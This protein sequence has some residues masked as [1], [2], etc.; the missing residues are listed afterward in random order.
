MTSEHHSPR[1]PLWLRKL[2]IPALIGGIAGFAASY[3]ML[4][5]ID[6]DMVGGLGTSESIAALVG[7]LYCVIAVGLLIGTANP[8]LGA[9]FLNVEDA[10]ELREQHRMLVYS[11]LAMVLWGVAL[12]A[13]ALAA[14]G[15]PVSQ[16]A[17]LAVGA[18]GLVIGTLL[19]VQSYRMS[20]ELMLAMNLEAAALTYSLAVLV[21]GT[22]AVIAHLGYTAGPQPLDLLTT[23]YVLVLVATFIVIGRRGMLTIK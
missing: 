20:D 4:H 8:R 21:L 19:A 5:F 7:V 1:Y 14:P 6:S 12:L 22:W 17:A 23:F 10:E 18:S 16:N 11:G 15:G 2:V 3:A 13:L 9:R